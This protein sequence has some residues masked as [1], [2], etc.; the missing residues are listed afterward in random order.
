MAA[1]R[2]ARDGELH[3]FTDRGECFLAALGFGRSL[4]MARISSTV[5]EACHVINDHRRSPT[6]FLAYGK[7]RFEEL[8]PLVA[9]VGLKQD[10]H[11]VEGAG[12]T[13]ERFHIASW[14]PEIE[15][16]SP[17]RNGGLILTL[18][19]HQGSWVVEADMQLMDTVTHAIV[20]LIVGECAPKDIK[21]RRKIGLGFGMLPDLTNILFV[22]PYLG[23]VAE[24]PIPFAIPTDFLSHPEVLDHWTYHTWLLTHSLL[25]WAVFILP[26]W[27]RSGGHKVAALAYAAHLVADLPSHSGIYGLEPLY[28]IRYVFSGWFD[29]WLWDPGPVIASIVLALLTYVVVRR[30][31]E[32]IL[33]PSERHPLGA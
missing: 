19:S 29:A 12:Q 5:F 26:W 13:H 16:T 27:R 23:W 28:P 2:H 4:S 11:A 14:I 3:V 24:R 30:M 31:R 33:W 10:P 22:H 17:S 21:H 32:R 18:C 8:G 15:N 25:F 6:D 9:L 7:V 1:A 20:G